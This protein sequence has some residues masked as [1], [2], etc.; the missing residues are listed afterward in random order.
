MN[1][2]LSLFSEED[3]FF[4]RDL[5]FEIERVN[6]SN[7]SKTIDIFS[8]TKKIFDENTKTYIIKELSNNF[9][10]FKIDIINICNS[11]EDIGIDNILSG[12]ISEMYDDKNNES[13]LQHI[14]MVTDDVVVDKPKDSV[15]KESTTKENKNKFYKTKK[16]NLDAPT[17][18]SEITEADLSLVIRG[19]IFNTEFI[20]TKNKDLKIFKAYLYD[21]TGSI[22]IKAFVKEKEFESFSKDFKNDSYLSVAGD[23][24][25]DQFDNEMSL[26]IKDYKIE[27][28]P[29]KN[30]TA[31]QKRFEIHAH[32]KMS[33]LSGTI[34]P[35]DLV[36]TVKKWG[37]KAI[38]ITDVG[39]IQAFP[40]VMDLESE[41]FK[42]IYG[43]EAYLLNDEE[44]FVNNFKKVTDTFVVFDI[45]TTGLNPYNNKIIEIGAVKI[46][47]N[48][49]IDRFQTFVNPNMKLPQFITNLTGI[50]D[51]DLVNEPDESIILPKFI[52]FIA[53][54]TMVA[55]NADF[56]I[57]FLE[58]QCKKIGIDISFQY[59]DT[60]KLSRYILTDLKKHKLDIISEKLGISLINHHRAVDD[61][62]ATSLIF[63][64]FIR[65]LIKL[66]KIIEISDIFNLT[67][68][69]TYHSGKVL[70]YVKNLTGLRNLYE[71]VSISH[72]K[73][74]KKIPRIP[75]SELK[76]LRDG[77]I[78]AA[79]G[80]ESDVF[81]TASS[82]FSDEVLRKKIDFYD[83]I[84]IQPKNNYK[85]H[86]SG[87]KYDNLSEVIDVVKRIIFLSKD[88]GKKVLAGGNVYELN[89]EDQI[90]RKILARSVGDFK[91][92][93][94]P[95]LVLMTTNEMLDSFDYLTENEKQEFVLDNL[96]YL[97][98]M[99]EKIRPI[100]L[101]KFPPIVEGSDETLRKTCY[102]KAISIYG[103]PLPEIVEKRLDKELN[104]IISNGYS[105][106]YIIAKN[107]V[108]KS[109][110]DGYLVG[111]RGSVGSSLAATMSGITEVNPLPAHYVCPNCKH[112]EFC[113]NQE[114]DAGVDMPDKLC[115]K[116]GCKLK[117]DGYTIPFETFLGF[118]GNKE[119]DIDLNFAGEYQS[120]AHK[121]TEDL[122]GE[123]FVFR[124]GTIGT[125]QDK[126]GFGYIKN[127][128]EETNQEIS[129]AEISRLI[130]SMVGIKKTTGQHPGG[131]MIVPKNKSIYDF[132]PVQYPADDPKTGVL[133]THFAYKA[134]HSNIL[135]L[136]ILGHDGPS[137]IKMLEDLT[138]IKIDNIKFDDQKVIELF[139]STE[140]IGLKEEVL[141]MKVGTLGIPEFGTNFVQNMLVETKP[142]NFSDL[143]RIS[144]LSHGTDVWTNNAQNLVNEGICKLKD[145]IATREDIMTYLQKAKL[146]DE[147][148]FFTMEKVRKGKNLDD[149]DIEKMK[150]AGLPDWYINSC[151]LIKYMFPKAHAVAYVM[152][153]FRIAWYK[154]NYPEAFYATFFTSKW[155]DFDYDTIT[156][157]LLSIERKIEEINNLEKRT[158][159]NDSTLRILEIAR[160]MYLR[161]IICEKAD[162]YK[163][164][165]KKFVITNGKII[166]PLICVPNLGESVANAISNEREISPFI[167]HEDLMKRTKINKTCL[168]YLIENEILGDMQKSNQ[169]SLF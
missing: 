16:I 59:I 110:S 72:T 34:D 163:S 152:L 161:G 25:F 147:F 7:S 92:E 117:K 145:V 118:T 78:I 107:L 106:M 24:K 127:Y 140:P 123:G 99:C 33:L 98:D 116:C 35:V 83:F 31:E 3:Q 56:D 6:F 96:D 79:E 109:E 20:D 70:I 135:K 154:I 167:S 51:E 1:S 137:M 119:P 76:R 111:S 9:P 10:G 156:K 80:R 148:A 82:G 146:D 61:A 151:Q 4:L 121:Y 155:A 114:Y 15:K 47:N 49:I 108:E 112:S 50:R 94:G 136:D 129:K 29:E 90:I 159:K 165:A 8:N 40:D 113:E 53:D 134:L 54:S 2:F 66:E 75:L 23:Y 142:R 141:G 120:T 65:R 131:I 128:F 101:E 158:A 105:V 85:F 164:N 39:D 166:P 28:K 100:P 95:E 115:P 86:L 60:L 62:E 144:G 143:I 11:T 139:N 84:E 67:F 150:K 43:L 102:D 73:Y 63:I 157:G 122:F 87:N 44:K 81:E 103:D 14:S 169:I 41:D 46:K 27:I 38:A 149:N 12:E 133:T 55:H 71:L 130:K 162:I 124:A 42:I 88:L 52:E 91:T 19:E 69:D 5:E 13:L 77:L 97:Y 132:S 125:I 36:K 32:T 22:L 168:N 58:T 93:K 21:G 160:E 48:Q 37:H 45:E 138:G 89:A 74:I 64:E 104:S 26:M 57:G 68:T 17:Q 153:S 126:I 30:D 18:I